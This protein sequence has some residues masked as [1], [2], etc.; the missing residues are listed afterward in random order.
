MKKL[1]NK[2]L[3]ALVV[4]IGTLPT[5]LLFGLKYSLCPNMS[6]WIATICIWIPAILLGIAWLVHLFINFKT[7][8]KR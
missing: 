6:Y 8:L 7:S 5:C 4:A 2:H 3:F 1:I